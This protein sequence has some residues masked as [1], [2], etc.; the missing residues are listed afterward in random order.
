VFPT[1]LERDA[2]LPALADLMLE[3]RHIARLQAAV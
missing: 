2:N 3:V 1:V